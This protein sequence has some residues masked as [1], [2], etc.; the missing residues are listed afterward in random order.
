MEYIRVMHSWPSSWLFPS[1]AQ[2]PASQFTNKGKVWV[3][4]RCVGRGK[5]PRQK[6][7]RVFKRWEQVSKKLKQ[8]YRL[9]KSSKAS[10][11]SWRCLHML[12]AFVQ[13]TGGSNM[14]WNKTARGHC[15]AKRCS[16]QPARTGSTRRVRGAAER[17]C[18]RCAFAADSYLLSVTAPRKAQ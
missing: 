7:A 5:R 10:W 4:R 9:L 17:A 3:S 6:T 8:C 13:A 15:A 1:K 14:K 11:I 18:C 2:R 12:I 16:R